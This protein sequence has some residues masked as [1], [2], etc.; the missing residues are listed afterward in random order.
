M[1]NLEQRAVSAL[2]ADPAPSPAELLTLIA[3]VEAG[4]TEAEAAAEQAKQN[5]LDPIQSPDINAA[6]A[7]VEATEFVGSRLRSLLVRL[8]DRYRQVKA[9]EAAAAWRNKY[10]GLKVA[11]DQLAAE[12]RQIYPTTVNTLVSLFARIGANDA[13][14]SQLHRGRPANAKGTLLSAE[15]VA[16]GLDEFSRDSPPLSKELRLPDWAESCRLVWPPRE[17]PASVLL[18]ES[19]SGD[20]DPRYSADWHAALK[21]D[22]RKRV[23]AEK[24]SIELEAAHQEEAK[25]QFEETLP[26]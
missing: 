12:L 18:S 17:T 22:V 25:R 1:K 8:E 14:L 2:S 6:R 13:A 11:R 19:M 3:E 10:E 5:F 24:K 16:R 9:A 26:R 7:K 15:L 20:A 23:A 21:A 4:I